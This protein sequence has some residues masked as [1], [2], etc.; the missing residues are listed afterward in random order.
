M[1]QVNFHK[2]GLLDLCMLSG[3]YE[4]MMNTQVPPGNAGRPAQPPGAG[5][6]AGP[7]PR[8]RENQKQ[9]TR[10]AIVDATRRLAR[11]GAEISMP[12]VAREA[13]VSEATAYRYFPDLA[14]LLQEADEGGWPDPAE[15]LAPVAD[16]TDP[17]E[18]VAYAA[19]FLLR[20]VLSYQG[21][22]RAMISASITKP[23]TAAGRPGHRFGLIDY[24]LAPVASRLARTNP[25]ALAQLRRDL[26]VVMSAEALFTLMDLCGLAPE[27]AITSA[28]TTARKIT[29]ASLTP[30]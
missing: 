3:D 9:R 20:G 19:E 24:A 6:Q 15:A 12:A 22:V 25:E 21:A 28:V 8:G 1:M 14:S 7:A 5:G 23:R 17:V 10:M 18:R 13:L 16:S 2:E 11:A 26:A 27:A 29:Q 30:P 4:T